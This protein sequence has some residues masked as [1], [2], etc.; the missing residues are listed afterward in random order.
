METNVAFRVG[1]VINR[2]GLCQ[3]HFAQI[4]KISP[5]SLCNKLNGRNAFSLADIENIAKYIPRLSLDWLIRGVGDMDQPELNANSV[6]GLSN[7]I[8]E[9]KSQIKQLRSSVLSQ[10]YKLD[11]II[12]NSPE[13]QDVI[14]DGITIEIPE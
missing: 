3:E 2:T 8:S 1:Q 13:L 14:G 11:L 10:S 12:S 5:Q 9:L 7:S 4:I 6:V